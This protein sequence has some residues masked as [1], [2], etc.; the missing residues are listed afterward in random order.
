MSD[1]APA[2]RR[3]GM[4]LEVTVMALRVLWSC[5]LLVAAFS[6]LAMLTAAPRSALARD[7]FDVT[8][9]VDSKNEDKETI[10]LITDDLGVKNQP[11][12]IDMSDMS[13]QFRAI[14]VGQSVTMS[15]A[16]RE[17]NSYLAYSIRAEGSY[18]E[19]ADLGTQ[20]RFE[21]QGS[22]IKAHKANTPEDDESL[23]QQHRQN[24]LRRD[25]DDDH[26]NDPSN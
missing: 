26:D 14:G 17:S 11:I 1:L 2:E 22:S 25:E 13:G 12:T 21:T 7:T 3:P 10:V 4:G 19:R 20:E 8:G 9:T 6:V 16:R 24:D 23:S 18:V 15:I 5:R